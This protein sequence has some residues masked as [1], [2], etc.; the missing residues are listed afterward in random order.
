MY[1]YTIQ[2]FFSLNKNMKYFYAV[3]ITINLF[4]LQQSLSHEQICNKNDN[5]AVNIFDYIQNKNFKI[6]DK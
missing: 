5:F 6:L 3:N 4:E 2:F 1:T